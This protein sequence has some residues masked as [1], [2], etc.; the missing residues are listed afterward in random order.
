MRTDVLVVG[1]GIAGLSFALKVSAFCRVTL[2]TKK[3]ST[4][5]ATNLAQGGIAAVLSAD[6]SSE[7]HVRDTLLSGDGVCNEGGVKL[8]V[9]DGEARVREWVDVGVRFQLGKAGK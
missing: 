4:D 2:I 6:D 1:S 3:M 5:T 8:V 7:V 9:K